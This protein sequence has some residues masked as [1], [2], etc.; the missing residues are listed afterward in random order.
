VSPRGRSD[1]RP[2]ARFR[3]EERLL[4]RPEYRRATAHGNRRTS[5]HF[6]VYLASNNIGRP[7]LGITASRKVG[8]AVVR[9]RVKRLIREYFRVS[10]HCLPPSRDVVVIARKADA[11]MRLQ[12]V[13]RELDRVIG[14]RR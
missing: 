1:A 11:E 3:K 8:K 13:M 10:K 12:E 4:L 7:R 6:V 5:A 2:R 9:N 14:V